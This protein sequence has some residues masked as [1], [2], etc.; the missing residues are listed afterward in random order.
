MTVFSMTGYASVLAQAPGA[1]AAALAPGDAGAAQ[2]GVGGAL[3]VELRSVNG[4]FLDLVFKL[5]EEL[6][7]S[8]WC[9]TPDM[10]RDRVAECIDLGFTHFMG[11]FVDAPDDSGMRLFAEQVA[12]N[13]R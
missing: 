13:F 10:V 6:R 9:G 4:R 5:P 2:A 12:P 1:G 11:W 3:S 8:W 7:E